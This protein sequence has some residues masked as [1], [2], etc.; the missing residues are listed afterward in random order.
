MGADSRGSD[1]GRRTGNR[2]RDLQ[3]LGLVLLGL[4]AVVGGVRAMGLRI[5]H[6]AS[7]PVGLYRMVDGSPDRGAIGLWCLPLATALIGRERGYLAAGACD[8]G[9]EPVGKRVLGVAG[10]TIQY[11]ARGVLLNGRAIANTQPLDQDS[12]GRPLVRLRFGTYVLSP[13]EVW[14]WS[15]GSPASWDSRYFGPIS[16][17]RLQALV[18]PVW[19]RQDP[20]LNRAGL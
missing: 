1:L 12:R 4:A 2:A 19:T 20:G 13:G 7:L 18:V 14:L 10:D 6:T 15:P 16:A 5:Q 11:G 8:G 3:R 9:A 17:T